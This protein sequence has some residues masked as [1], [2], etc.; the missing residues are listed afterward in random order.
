MILLADIGNSRIKCVTFAAHQFDAWPAL[1]T[2]AAAPFADLPAALRAAAQPTR[3]LV[4]NVAG[5]AAAEKLRAFV[6]SEWG[7]TPEF[8]ATRAEAGGMTTAY[9]EPAK[10]GVDRWLA[11]LA[12][13]RISGAMVCVIDVGTALTVDVVTVAGHHLGGLIAPGPELMRASLNRATAQLDSAPL[14]NV[15]GFATNTDDAISLGCG[16]ATQGLLQEVRAR[17]TALDGGAQAE[18]FVTGG[19][20]GILADMIDWPHTHDPLLVQRGLLLAAGGAR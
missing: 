8:V 10:L 3:V 7:L 2:A 17:L 19:G 13:W 15:H 12:A 9:D 11:A 16:S 18:W 14:H 1:D 4:S 6:G 5:A 20:A